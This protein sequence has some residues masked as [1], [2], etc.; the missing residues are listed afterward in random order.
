MSFS[1][2]QQKCKTCDKTVHLV[3]TLSADGNVYHKNCFRCH[4]CNGLL[5]VYLQIGFV[6]KS[7]VMFDLNMI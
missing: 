4:Q 6:T 1:G 7:Y 5:A 2:T 3:D